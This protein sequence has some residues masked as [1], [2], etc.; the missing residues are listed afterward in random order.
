MRSECDWLGG[1]AFVPRS[2]QASYMRSGSRASVIFHLYRHPASP[3]KMICSSGKYDPVPIK[4]ILTI[5]LTP[6]FSLRRSTP[7]LTYPPA[8]S[9]NVLTP[10]PLVLQPPPLRSW[11]PSLRGKVRV[12]QRCPL[13]RPRRQS[14]RGPALGMIA[15]TKRS[16]R[17]STR[18]S[19]CST[20]QR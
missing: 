19:E 20:C 6:L 4:F 11:L 10:L 3:L 5:S 1:Y 9:P 12:R 17:R 8:T 16:W 15:S 7:T 14:E 2:D 13:P 18:T